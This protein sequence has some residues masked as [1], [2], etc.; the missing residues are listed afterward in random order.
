MLSASTMVYFFTL[1]LIIYQS[2]FVWSETI[3]NSPFCSPDEKVNGQCNFDG[4][5]AGKKRLSPSDL[6]P[7]EVFTGWDPPLNSTI[8]LPLKKNQVIAKGSIAQQMNNKNEELLTSDFSV[9]SEAVPRETVAEVLSLLRFG[10]VN[11]SSDVTYKGQTAV[12]L[13]MDPDT[14][15]GMSTQEIFLDN[16]SLREGKGSKEGY[17]QMIDDYGKDRTELRRKIRKRLDPILDGI[18]TPFVRRIYGEKCARGG[19]RN[20]TPCYSLIRRYR[21]NERVSHAPHHDGHSLVTVVV[22]LSDYNREYTGGLYVATEN[23][24]RYYLGL[25]RGDAVA[26]Q[27]DLFHGVKIL[28]D[29]EDRDVERWSWIL[30]YR[31]SIKCVDYSAEWFKSCAEE[32]NS[33]CQLIHSTKTGNQNDIVYWNQKAC[34][35][36][37]GSACVKLARAHLG[38]LSS[39]LPFDID[40]A[41]QLYQ[42]AITWNKEPDGYY[43]LA[44]ILLTFASNFDMQGNKLH[45][46]STV[47]P[48]NPR[49]MES[50]QHLEAAAFS[51]HPYAMFNLGIAHLYGYGHENGTQNPNLA[52]EWF[53]SC[54]L[55][56]G[57]AFA[58]EYLQ[59]IGNKEKAKQFQE[60]AKLLG[61]GT[62]W[63]QQAR[64]N[65]G[66][67]GA[68]GVSLNL[69]W[70]SLSSNRNRPPSF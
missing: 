15:D 36:G 40:K 57:Y 61:Y 56:E 30:W 64:E 18:I 23:S 29:E 11:V 16:D 38:M 37:Q 27:S 4:K 55:P 28:E 7:P 54:G 24:Q 59:S 47:E 69:N 1:V 52:V 35:N 3:Y 19:E 66:S 60:R 32:G 53:I 22:S 5:H 20:C 10:S 33:K 39:P 41:Q 13:D 49:I 25:N 31:D 34:E 44:I 62:P 58:A 51:G 46:G 42:R 14:V 6:P 65:T 2:S 21:R 63:R 17:S 12:P 50:I 9:L 48:D 70:P 8:S 68:S 26:H 45:E 43:G 67:G